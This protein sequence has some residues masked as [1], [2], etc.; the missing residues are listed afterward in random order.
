MN[1]YLLTQDAVYG[2]DT[3]DS[4]IVYAEDIASARKIHPNGYSNG[5]E[6]SS[7]TWV[8]TPNEVTVELIG[9]TDKDVDSGVIQASF[10]AG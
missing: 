7:G 3:Y 8:D 2:Y 10:N 9:S 1:I 6:R 5:W 4:C